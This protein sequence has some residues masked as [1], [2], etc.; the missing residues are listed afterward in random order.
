M[1]HSPIPTPFAP[2]SSHSHSHLAPQNPQRPISRSG[3]PFPEHMQQYLQQQPHY[4]PQLQ[5]PPLPQGYSSSNA[6]NQGQGQ[7][8]GQ[9]SQSPFNPPLQQMQVSDTR[10]QLFVSNLPFRVRW[11]DLVSLIDV[12]YFRFQMSSETLIHSLSVIQKDLMRKCGTVL[13]AD[14]ALSPTDGFVQFFLLSQRSS[15]RPDAVPFL[16]LPQSK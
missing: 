16:I 8:Q 14:V 7:G 12:S 3:S 2:H 4:Q 11:Q 6:S 5:R 15:F 9:R 13:R 1:N 10:T